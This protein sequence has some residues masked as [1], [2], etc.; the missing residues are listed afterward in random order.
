[1]AAIFTLAAILWATEALPL[2]ATALL[3][4]ALQIVLLANP[5]G[6]RHLGFENGNSPGSGLQTSL[7]PSR[8]NNSG[9]GSS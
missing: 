3:T 1:M 6:W 8:W 4:L 7:P 5:G 9:N 2:F